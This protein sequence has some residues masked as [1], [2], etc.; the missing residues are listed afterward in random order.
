MST[1]LTLNVR[2]RN[3]T[4]EGGKLTEAI[5]E[6]PTEEAVRL[7]LSGEAELSVEQDT[8]PLAIL[9]K[10]TELVSQ[11]ENLGPSATDAE[12]FENVSNVVFKN[13]MRQTYAA[14]QTLHWSSSFKEAKNL[15]EITLCSC[16][17]A[18]CNIIA[19]LRTLCDH[20]T[21]NAP[22][23][24]QSMELS[25]EQLKK[26]RLVP[27]PK[28][29]LILILDQWEYHQLS[30]DWF[31]FHE[32]LKE[33]SAEIRTIF[34]QAITDGRILVG[35]DT[36]KGDR[37]IPPELARDLIF[38][39]GKSNYKYLLSSNLPKDWFLKNETLAK[40]K[41][42]AKRWLERTYEAIEP[43]GK[44]WSQR[45]ICVVLQEKFGLTPNAALDVC[46][47][48]DIPNRLKLGNIPT[49]ERADIGV[50]RKYNK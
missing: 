3:I 20:H 18:K 31:G 16:P 37:F 24:N 45:D 5:I 2:M 13:G 23:A 1:D 12:V 25:K 9:E 14:G 15:V 4:G 46:N 33:L 48:S 19:Q 10:V 42:N 34:N 21:R 36:P 38:K 8:P 32:K 27:H 41:A 6:L 39:R 30:S 43:S 17:V 35:E 50:L 22:E 49:E 28:N 26:H 47:N 44:R 7:V 11:I 29:G 40:T